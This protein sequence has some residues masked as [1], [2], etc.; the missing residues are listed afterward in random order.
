MNIFF[1]SYD[2]ALNSK[3]P[4]YW[5]VHKKCNQIIYNMLWVWEIILFTIFGDKNPELSQKKGGKAMEIGRK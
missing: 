4:H 2:Y 5:N 3:A 1:W